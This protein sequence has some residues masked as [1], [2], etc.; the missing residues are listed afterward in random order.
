[1][2]ARKPAKPKA[3]LGTK[4]PLC[5][6]YAEVVQ[7]RQTIIETQLARPTREGRASTK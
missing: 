5:V 7:L 1:M 4:K 3:R 2:T 6:R